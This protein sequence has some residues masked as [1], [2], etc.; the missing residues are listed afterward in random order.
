[1]ADISGVMSNGIDASF[2]LEFLDGFLMAV[3]IEGGIVNKIRNNYE[4]KNT[5]MLKFR[6]A[7]IT[8][9]YTDPY[10]LEI[11]YS[12]FHSYIFPELPV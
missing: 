9:D 3:G 11:R 7:E 1:M 12:N 4:S 8:R 6:F 5:H 2:G 10:W